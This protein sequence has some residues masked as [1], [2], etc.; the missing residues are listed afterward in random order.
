MY[1]LNIQSSPR[2]SRSA[3]I[4]VAD[5]FVEAH[6]QVCPELIVDTLNVWEE[7]LPVFDQEAIGAKY[8]GINQ[9]PMNEAAVCYSCCCSS[10]KQSVSSADV[11]SMRTARM[12]NSK[13]ASRREA[14]A[15]T[16]QSRGSGSLSELTRLR[17]VRRVVKADFRF[18]AASNRVIAGVNGMIV[19]GI[20]AS[21]LS[22]SNWSAGL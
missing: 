11:M 14:C 2:R 6:R 19:V 7:N 9:Q 12:S 4:A 10:T 5:A 8:K 16:F 18:S 13:I 1:L 3:S 17:F 22:F 21:R 15:H 20:A